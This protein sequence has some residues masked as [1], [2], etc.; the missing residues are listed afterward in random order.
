MTTVEPPAP[1]VAEPPGPAVTEPPVAAEPPIPVVVPPGTLAAP[2]GTRSVPGAPAPSTGAFSLLGPA[3]RR[4]PYAFYRV[5]REEHPLLWD[6][7]LGAWLVGRYADV[8]PA[9]GGD[10]LA[11]ARGGS[12]CG[13][14]TVRCAQEYAAPESA[15]ALLREVC[16]RTAYVLARRL[17]DRQEADL[18]EEF[19]RWLPTGT[20]AAAAGL[21]YAAVLGRSDGPPSRS[22]AEAPAAT[23]V[24]RGRG[25]TGVALLAAR[26]AGQAVLTGRALASL[27]ANLLDNPEQLELVRAV[28]ALIGQAWEESLRRNPPVHVVL[29]RARHD[30][31]VS[32]GTIPAGAAVALLVGAANR[33]PDRFAAPDLFDL[34]R[35][36]PGALTL[37]PAHCPGAR[38]AELQAECAV[39]ALLDAM[40]GLRRADAFEA[41]ESGLLTRAPRRLLV[42]PC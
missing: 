8:A 12:C 31:A 40:P 37:G 14:G 28:P 26:C 34:H 22:R 21:P 29:R 20:I 42:R 23:D 6:G 1:V 4:D 18:V 25:G 33:D 30:L 13:P 17:A 24:G 9:L 11:G 19:C 36:A 7:R 35:T 15:F 32:G 2:A 38:V 5:L 3:A 39:G 27:M 16:A 41:T 10:G